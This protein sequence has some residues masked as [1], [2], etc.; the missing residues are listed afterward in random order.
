MKNLFK[1]S[2]LVLLVLTANLAS[3]NVNFE[4]I[5]IFSENTKSLNL[6]LNN[7]D[8]GLDVYIKDV[9]G[10]E[11][12]KEQFNG[13][14]FSKKFD[15]TLL[16]DGNYFFEIEGQTK[17]SLLPFKVSGL[18]VE[19][20]EMK[21]ELIHKPIVRIQND[22]IFISKFSPD[23]ELLKIAFYDADDNLLLEEKLSNNIMAGKVFNISK[24]TSGEY[25]LIA[26]DS[27]NRTYVH[28]IVK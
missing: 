22:L 10:V 11:L 14:Q 27:Y 15:L 19:V 20:L 8:G 13:K 24:L 12:Y 3:A 7:N 1:K 5:K 2:A 16:P 6:E 23:K 17:I 4:N 26:K 18:K 25:R 9:Y 21:K 28:K